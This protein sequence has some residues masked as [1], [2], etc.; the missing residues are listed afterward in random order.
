MKKLLIAGVLLATASISTAQLKMPAP[1]P[2]QFVRQ[3]FGLGT[4]ELTYSRPVA[5]GRKIFGDLVPYNKVW[6]TGA[7][8][9]TLIRFTEPVEMG[10][11]RVDS[12]T[13]ALYT[14]PGEENWEVILNK[15]TGNWG[16][17]GYKESD[18]V[19]RFKVA[20]YKV[21]PA[22][23]SFTM[24]LANVKPVTCELQISWEKTAV[25]IP[26]S[27]NILDKMR[28]QLDKA[29]AGDKKPYFSAAQYYNEYDKNPAKALEN[30]KLAVQQNPNAYWMWLYKARIESDMG[31]KAAAMESSKKSL[32]L[33][34]EQ[35][36]DD[37]VKM[38]VDLQKK[39]R[40]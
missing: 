11:K 10:G 24:Q 23:E 18:D 25:T 37:Y 9:A 8:N 2:T 3:D 19:A 4:I 30:I 12:G 7:N 40:D 1:S 36:N 20:S 34:T 32:Q 15:G 14:I 39:L 29:M 26:I 21:K 17:N 38:N 22:I 27:M 35:K 5:K 31:D 16:I 6:R 13:Y 33:A 28:V